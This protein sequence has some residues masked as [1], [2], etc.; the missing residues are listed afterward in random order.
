MKKLF[1]FMMVS[2]DGFFEGKDHDLRWHNVDGEFN[3]FAAE[4]LDEVDT[5]LF[6]RKTYELMASFWP[7][8]QPKMKETAD[9]EVA[10]KMNSLTKIVCSRTLSSA[11]W[12]QQEDSIIIFN[13]NSAAE[14]MKLKQHSG[15]DI[16]LLGSNNL[17]V[18]L[19]SQGLIDEVRIMINPVAIGE[20]TRLFE[21]MAGKLDFKLTKT[22]IFTS[23][24]VLLRY[25]PS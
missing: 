1:L 18:S 16:A 7:T 10:Q 8:Y 24:N 5:L 25:L 4:Q 20:G 22:R 14:I 11:P 17:S 3:T 19:F 6:G 21:G 13:D 15:K 12:G 9:A 2:L 23:G